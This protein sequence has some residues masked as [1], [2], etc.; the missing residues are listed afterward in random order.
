[1][2]QMI[3]RYG[4][5]HV[6]LSLPSLRAGTLTPELM[7]HIKTVRKTGFTIAP[8]AGSQRLR[9]IINKN[10]TAQDI[11]QTVQDAFALGWNVI[12][13]YFMIGLPTETREDLEALVALAQE[14]SLIKRPGG[15]RN[16][17]NVSVAT[18]IPKPHTPFQWA[19]QIGIA[20][21]WEKITWIKNA[22]RSP[23]I[24]LKW[25]NPEVSHIEGL[26]ARGDR[27]MAD[28]IL[29]AY[30]KGC[31]LDGWSDHFRF[32]LWEES[33]RDLGL[34]ADA[35]LHRERAVDEAFPWD[36]IDMKVKRSYLWKEWQQALRGEATEDCR[37]GACQDC[38]VCDFT[39]VKPRI[40]PAEGFHPGPPAARR[41]SGGGC[42]QFQ[43][44]FAKTGYG[45][46]WGHLE[47]VNI[48]TRALRR[49]GIP[50]KFSAGFHPKPKLVFSD[51]LPVGME[52]LI[53]TL[54][55][56]VDGDISSEDLMA[57][58]NAQ[59]PEG[60]RITDCEPYDRAVSNTSR[61]VTY[62]I[63]IDEEEF[64][65]Q[66]LEQFH[67]AEAVVYEKTTRKGRLKKMDL[68][69]MVQRME[70]PEGNI[71]EMDLVQGDGAHLR[72]DVVLSRVFGLP[73]T[74]IRQ[75]RIIKLR[76]TKICTGNPPATP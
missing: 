66:A 24:R 12:K 53:E 43:A 72:P 46:F 45:R 17:I 51:A 68:K 59:L 32:D 5:D 13:L 50:L 4:C 29:Q 25:Q 9:D 62:R 76:Q 48:F 11:R 67:A 63:M 15:G 60:L 26:M 71:L 27:R 69:A 58:I 14:L 34:D 49:A 30:R 1:M 19:P 36:H 31:R 20:E 10:V 41:S 61:V 3:H 75:A 8:E 64:D 37:D 57:R 21:G 74:L 18:L 2:E 56:T 52:S 38:G 16:T 42:Q 35:I 39:T 23:R 44:N 40:Y 22:L 55:M 47:M 6:A 65:A 73:S 33:I 7:Q 28:L 54:V 70:C